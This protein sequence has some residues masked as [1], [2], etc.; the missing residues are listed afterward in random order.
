MTVYMNEKTL[1]SLTCTLQ[2]GCKYLLL[3]D[4]LLHTQLRGGGEERERGGEGGGERKREVR[5]RMKSNRRGVCT[6]TKKNSFQYSQHSHS[7]LHLRTVQL[8]L[9]SCH[10]SIHMYE[11]S[12]AHSKCAVSV[13]WST[14][15]M[16]QL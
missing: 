16:S 9:R 11:P 15:R 4:S 6:V 13:S 12:K 7:K 5:R 14:H 10:P 8:V 3:G 1:C 2:G